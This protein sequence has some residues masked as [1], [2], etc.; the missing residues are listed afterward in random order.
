MGASLVVP[1]H[2]SHSSH[3]G[4]VAQSRGSSQALLPLPWALKSEST[5]LASAT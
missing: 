4:A 2:R 5:P 3:G 1:G